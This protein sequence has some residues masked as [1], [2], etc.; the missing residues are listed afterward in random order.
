MNLYMFMVK[1]EYIVIPLKKLD[2]QNFTTGL[3][4]VEVSI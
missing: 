2:A 4:Q 3:D 1:Y